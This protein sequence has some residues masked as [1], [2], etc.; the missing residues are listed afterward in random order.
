MFGYYPSTFIFSFCNKEQ[1]QEN[2]KLLTLFFLEKVQLNLKIKT[3]NFNE[4]MLCVKSCKNKDFKFIFYLPFTYLKTNRISIIINILNIDEKKHQLILQIEK[5]SKD[6]SRF[7]NVSLGRFKSNK[8]NSLFLYLTNALQNSFTT[9]TKEINLQIPKNSN[10]IALNT[11]VI[12]IVN[13]NKLVRLLC[14]IYK[15]FLLEKYKTQPSKEIFNFYYE[16]TH[17]I[18]TSFDNW[19]YLYGN[20]RDNM[21]IGQFYLN[22]KMTF[23]EKQKIFEFEYVIELENKTMFVFGK[24]KGGD[25]LFVTK[26]IRCWS[27]VKYIEIYRDRL[28]L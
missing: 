14:A 15:S 27:R 1:F 25:G 7:Y 8:N 23:G 2:S 17:F 24:V 28:N 13:Q 20:N 4:I 22:K 18:R 5:R 11:F 3:N 21:K 26:E 19:Y 10:P 9:I 12:S 6:N 16:D